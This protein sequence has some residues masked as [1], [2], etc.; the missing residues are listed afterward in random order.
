MSQMNMYRPGIDVTQPKLVPQVTWRRKEKDEMV[1]LWKA[2]IYDMHH[3]MLSVK[4]TRVPGA[5]TDE[6]LFAA[7]AGDSYTI[8]NERYETE[9]DYAGL[10]TEEEKKQLENSLKM[11]NLEI[12]DDGM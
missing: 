8:D 1:G 11:D 4:S 2:R 6:E 10:L 7:F 9:E 3:V 12:G 5:M